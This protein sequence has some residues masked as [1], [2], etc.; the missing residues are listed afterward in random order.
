M[1]ELIVVTGLPRSGTS[2]LMSML[3]A[4]GV[5]VLADQQRPADQHNPRG[6]YEHGRLL[7]DPDPNWLKEHGGQ[8]IKILYRQLENVPADLE[9]RVLLLERD[10]REVV[11]SQQRMRP[12]PDLDWLDLFTRE[13]RR[14]KGWLAR[15]RWPVLLVQH[16][17]LLQDQQRQLAEI[18]A[19]LGL[20]LNLQAMVAQVDPSLYRCRSC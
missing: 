4:G 13:L 5:P 3:E 16:R 6:Y 9:A 10:L 20:E 15:Q 1:Q 17:R 8:A 2:L 11:E 19:F 14:F 7:S 18:Q 12:A